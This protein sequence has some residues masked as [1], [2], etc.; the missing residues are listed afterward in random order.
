M[1]YYVARFVIAGASAEMTTAVSDVL[2]AMVGDIGFEAFEETAEGLNGYVQ[3]DAL[4][5]ALLDATLAEL[6]FEGIK[7]SYAI[8][9]A[10]DKDYNA[11]WEETGFEPIVIKDKIV[12]HDAKSELTTTTPR[13][14]E[15]CRTIGRGVPLW[16]PVSE[17][18]IDITID[19]RQA[20][21]TGTHETTRMIIEW[22]VQQ[23][24]NVDISMNDVLDCGCGTGI[25]SI[26]ASKLGARHIL[27]YDIDEWS[28]RNTRHNAELNGCKNIDV[29]HGRI[30]NGQLVSLCGLP[31]GY[32]PTHGGHTSHASYDYKRYNIVLAN[33]TRNILLTDMPAMANMLAPT[34]RLVMSGF[35][36]ADHG[37]LL[38][39]AHNLGLTLEEMQVTNGSEWCMLSFVPADA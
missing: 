32:A 35:Y 15:D 33:L 5:R 19:A 37:M 20:F 10:E 36:S 27:A 39:K 31:Q 21:G 1:K 30:D 8:E 29:M 26:A 9:E 17:H 12:I 22:L 28:V 34:G 16:S 38:D 24:E 23:A 13:I 25:L 11:T 4:D 6:P 14:C 3:R 2:A 18:V 7:V